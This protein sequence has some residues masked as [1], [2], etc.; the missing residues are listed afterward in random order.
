MAISI[1]DKV[2]VVTSITDLK[3]TKKNHGTVISKVG[4][5]G[6]FTLQYEDKSVSPIY[7]NELDTWTS[8]GGDGSIREKVFLR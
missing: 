7:S 4:E 1:G 5:L 2:T 6:T 3:I 8:L